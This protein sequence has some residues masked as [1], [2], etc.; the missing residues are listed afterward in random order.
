MSEVQRNDLPNLARL[1]MLTPLPWAVVVG[2][3]LVFLILDWASF[4]RPLQGLNITPWNPQPALAVALLMASR[5]LW[6]V[7]IGGLL[8]A[9]VL[10]RGIPG[11]VVVVTLAA[12]ALT[13][14]YL[15]MAAALERKLGDGW[16]VSTGRD[17]A[18]FLAII[19]LGA[20]LS[21][22]VYVGTYA[23]G[24]VLPP[25][26]AW[27]ALARYWVGDAV[28]MTV[29]LPILLVAMDADRR[30]TLMQTL[31]Q[32]Q[33]WLTAVSIAMLLGLLSGG[34][35][36]SFNYAYLLLLPV[37]WA[38]MRF[39]IAGAVLAAALTQIG[40]IVAMQIGA[41]QDGFV[42]E[43]QLLM[44][45]ITTTG[46]LLG[47][48]VDERARSDAELRSSLRMAAAGQMSAALAHEL[49]QPLTALATYAQTCEL[50]VADPASLTPDRQALLVDVT[51]RISADARR[52]GDVVKRLRDFFQTGATHLQACDMA[53]LVQAE[54]QAQQRRADTSAIR[55][56]SPAPGGLP[57]VWVDEVQIQVVLRNLVGNALDSASARGEPGE[58][59]VRLSADSSEILVE[60]LDSGSGVT[61][62]QA[63]SVFEP[64]TS[65]KVGGMGVG[66]GICRAIVEA[67]GGRLWALPGPVGHFCFTLAR[68]GEEADGPTS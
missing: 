51:R 68:E 4:I 39:G 24:G 32:G 52:A 10:V 38:S 62:T 54:L 61:P 23:A 12:A 29:T 49:S 65:T 50:L 20:L 67:H 33:W 2:Y 9:E 7:V 42:V 6:W 31:R 15:A 34:D 28:G 21:G 11:D 3:V 16:R 48:T 26:P 43:L 57:K 58:V 30:E 22:V 46:L 64:G 53:Q 37:I 55:L 36:E 8:A 47:V 66:L 60:V 5:R 63:L 18:W 41:H 44:A 19:A 14:S 45:A 27:A 56:T 17:V 25:G 35:E 40:L 1:P 13:C 59:T